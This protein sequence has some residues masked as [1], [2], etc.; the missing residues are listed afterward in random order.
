MGWGDYYQFRSSAGKPG[1]HAIYPDL[2]GSIMGLGIPALAAIALLSGV[3]GLK[4]AVTG[5]TAAYFLLLFLLYMFSRIADDF[6]RT[7]LY[8]LI[9]L[10][11][12]GLLVAGVG[13]AFTGYWGEP[14]GRTAC[15]VITASHMVVVLRVVRRLIPPHATGAS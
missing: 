4:G 12:L 5:E 7:G 3:Q 8:G 2:R 6:P 1:D 14:S 11:S 10:A 9:A 15:W 13:I